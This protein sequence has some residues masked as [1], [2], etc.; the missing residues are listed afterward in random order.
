[1]R[2]IFRDIYTGRVIDTSIPPGA[3][4]PR[5]DEYVM[6]RFP[7]RKTYNTFESKGDL[8]PRKYVVKE[9][10]WDLSSI[11][12]GSGAAPEISISVQDLPEA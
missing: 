12:D 8:A 6:L 2:V 3:N 7:A 9:V 5:C 10:V 11:N 4:I 1:M